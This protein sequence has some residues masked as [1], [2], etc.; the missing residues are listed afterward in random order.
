MSNSDQEK[1]P[2]T[3]EEAA[4]EVLSWLSAEDRVRLAAKGRGQLIDEHFGLAMA[5]RNELGLRHGN[6][7]LLED[8]WRHET[9]QLY[10]R[11]RALY[12]ADEASGVIVERAWELA[13]A[14]G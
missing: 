10:S 3:V 1:Q 7:E 6:E 5:I 14:E 2:A 9:S 12:T 13:R 11:F 4:R 8:C